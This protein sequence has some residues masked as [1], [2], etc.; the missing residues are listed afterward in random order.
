MDR[1]DR[2]PYSQLDIG[3]GS[4]RLSV[5][6][7]F[8]VITISTRF[9]TNSIQSRFLLGSYFQGISEPLGSSRPKST[10]A[11]IFEHV[12]TMRGYMSKENTVDLKAIKS[13]AS[14]I[15][16]PITHGFIKGSG[17]EAEILPGGGDWILVCE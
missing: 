2:R 15:I 7:V 6:P 16:V 5:V 17:L 13:G 14:R 9:L 1:L 3:C 12:F 4:F 10:M 8:E 11:P